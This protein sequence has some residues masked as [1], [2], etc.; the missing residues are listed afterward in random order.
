MLH[1]LGRFAYR[2]HRLVLGLSGLAFILLTAVGV[3]AFTALLDGGQSDP[4]SPSARAEGSI[5]E[6]FGGQQGLV[7][8][9]TARQSTLTSPSFQHAGA[10]ITAR[11]KDQPFI[12]NVTSYFTTPSAQ[13]R[14]RDGT[15]AL[16]LAHVRQSG[17]ASNKNVPALLDK[18]I[19]DGGPAV[20]V[21]TGGQ[22]GTGAA[23]STQ[24]GKDLA[25]V[26][27]VAI[28][29]TVV[30]LY[31]VFGGLTAALLP[32]VV[33]GIAIMGTFAELKI[34]TFFTD[35]GTYAIDLTLALG[36]GLAVDYS[37]LLINR[38][39]E[40]VADGADLHA[41]VA[42]ATASAGRTILFSA[43][44]VAVSLTSLLVF[45][46]YFLRSFAYAGIAVVLFA[47]LGALVTLPA[48]L[49]VAGRRAAVPTRVGRRRAADPA[50]A[51]AAASAADSPFWTRLVFAVTAR[52][53]LTAVP[54]VA[55]LAVLGLPLL[56][57]HFS[58]PDE[59]VLPTSSP[60]HQ[61]GDILKDDFAGHANDALYAV[62]TPPGSVQAMTATR[63]AATT[64]EAWQAFSARL[65]ALP[66][67]SDVVGPAGTYRDGHPT[68]A[69]GAQP[70]QT[71]ARG[72]LAYWTIDNALNPTD[73]AAQHLVQNVRAVAA[74]RG[75]RVT[76]GGQAAD[77]VDQKHAI[78]DS[79]PWAA[80]IIIIAAFVVLFLFTGSLLIPL[81]ALV[82]NGL[83]LF[84][85]LGVMVWIFQG[86]H[87]SGLLGFTP[88]ATTTT[89][90]PLVFII[91]FGLSMDYEV[92]LISRIKELHDAGETNR[93]AIV[94]GMAKTGRIVTAAAAL[95]SVTFFAFGLS[96]IS[97]LQ[98]FG[99]GTAIAILLDATV[100]RGTLVPALM[101]VVGERIWWAPAPLRRLHKRIGLSEQS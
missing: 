44:T 12:S 29:I 97:F 63:P 80:A 55:V 67:V 37:L 22:S 23:L 1:T 25:L 77:I 20:Q 95:L 2:R 62:A 99:L 10:A 98:F 60:A 33:A 43:L 50:G 32:L 21:R 89:M 79:L 5:N 18:L 42:R 70:P 71:R 6:Q 27:I 48:L 16:V 87:L 65:S 45:P 19:T 94:G 52:P 57:V 64:R 49:A 91:A 66:G 76:V 69:A 68:E 82:L 93:D 73:S 58:T 40:E 17:D 74:P 38:Y 56:N 84:A 28:P 39:R 8:V 31:F 72:S 41:A 7:V 51:H 54:V 11:L 61:V 96:K 100:I 3:T 81:K 13:L 92:F 86:G 26:S 14:S 90:P 85:V 35:V 15:S 9:V 78:V 24:I 75:T 30:L 101:Q 46:L 47:V 88:A 36:I 59:R 53:L 4:Q 34:L 83:L